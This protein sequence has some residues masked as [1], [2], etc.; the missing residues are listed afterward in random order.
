MALPP[1]IPTSFVPRSASATTHQLRSQLTSTFGLFSYAVLGIVFVLALSV[2]FYDQILSGAQTE[3]HSALLKQQ[4]A[5]DPATIGSF[6]QLRDRLNSGTLLLS[7]HVAFSNFFELLET[8][9]P[10][11]VRFNSL[12]LTMN[13][14]KKVKIEGF[15]VARNFNALAAVSTAFAT[16][17]HIKDAIFSNITVN[18]D[19]SVSFALS[20]ALDPKVITFS[21]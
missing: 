20:A 18:K 6:V 4:E 7:N 14:I 11:S 8:I 21:P 17:G 10:N 2:F 3:R 16:D 19:S 12:H 15:G 13:D 1:T 5:I 9:L